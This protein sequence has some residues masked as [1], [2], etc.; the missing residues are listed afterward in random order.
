[1]SVVASFIYSENGIPLA[2]VDRVERG[3]HGRGKEFL[4][5]R[6]LPGGGFAKKPGLNGMKLPLY[7]VDEIRAAI[8]AGATIYVVEGEGNADALRDPLRKAGST[9]A[10]TTLFGGAT[11]TLTDAQLASLSRAPSVVMLADSDDSGRKA[12][13]ARAL[14]IVAAYP[15]CDMRAIDLYADRTDGSDVADWLNEGHTLDELRALV[16]FAPRVQPQAR[17][18]D[19]LVADDS[20]GK[21]VTIRASDVHAQRIF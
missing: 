21:L 7:R 14:R 16:D 11:A 4:P 19:T 13:T 15:A 5:Y 10:V 1:M 2:R 18:G 17:G 8:E 3:R 20:V 6:A 9:A 12:A